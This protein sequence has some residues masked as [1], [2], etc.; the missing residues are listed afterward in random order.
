MSVTDR[1]DSR[2]FVLDRVEDQSGISGTGVVAEGI[3]FSDGTVV[4]RWRTHIKSTSI[5]ESVR[6]V[7]AIHGHGGRT[8]IRFIESRPITESLIFASDD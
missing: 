3:E 8:R 4:M 2:L 7:E 5:Y 6:A 1:I